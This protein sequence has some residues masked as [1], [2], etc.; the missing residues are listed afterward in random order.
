MWVR[1]MIL[2]RPQELAAKLWKNG[3]PLR[4]GHY[5]HAKKQVD[6]ALLKRIKEISRLECQVWQDN[7]K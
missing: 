6:N 3:A 5:P 2:I 4:K 7:L 1:Q